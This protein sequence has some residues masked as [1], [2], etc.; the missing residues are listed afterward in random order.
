VHGGFALPSAVIRIEESQCVGCGICSSAC[1]SK[2]IQLR[3][4][5]DRQ[6]VA[7]AE[8]LMM[9]TITCAANGG[10]T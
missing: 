8:A 7:N 3:H 2:A 10:R 6:V 9:E 1:P 5:R 4:Y